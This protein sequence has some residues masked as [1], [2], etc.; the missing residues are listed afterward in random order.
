MLSREVAADL[1]S[2]ERDHRSSRNREL[3][4]ERRLLDAGHIADELDE[5]R[6]VA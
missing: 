2:G 6:G 1:A 5:P 4:Q 3:E